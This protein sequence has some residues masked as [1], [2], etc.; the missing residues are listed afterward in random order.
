MAKGDIEIFVHSPGDWYLVMKA[1][2]QGNHQSLL[3]E[4]R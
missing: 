2:P 1:T 4:E 3:E